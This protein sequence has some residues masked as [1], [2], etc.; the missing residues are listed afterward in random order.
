MI[1][2]TKSEAYAVAEFID[3]GLLTFIREDEDIDS[4]I[5]LR[6]MVMAFE[7][8]RIYSGFEPLTYPKQECEEG[9]EGNE[10][11]CGS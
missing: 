9:G 8:L 1:E 10:R 6:N 11:D 2:L 7:K 4:M 5:W 3:C